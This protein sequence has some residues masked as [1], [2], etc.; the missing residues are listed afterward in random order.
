MSDLSPQAILKAISDLVSGGNYDSGATVAALWGE[1]QHALGRLVELEPP[2]PL[3][4]PKSPS[5]ALPPPTDVLRATYGGY[6]H[7]AID[8]LHSENIAQ[9]Q[10]D[11]ALRG[12]GITQQND[13][14]AASVER[15]RSERMNGS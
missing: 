12:L 6:S 2:R 4:L 5:G 8:D 13:E 11:Q 10:R 1:Y 15:E 9:N 3:L 14:Y 7:Q